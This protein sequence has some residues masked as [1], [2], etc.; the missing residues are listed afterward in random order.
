VSF[1]MFAVLTSA[2]D[3]EVASGGAGLLTGRSG[4]GY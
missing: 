1:L 4:D 2:T 3:R